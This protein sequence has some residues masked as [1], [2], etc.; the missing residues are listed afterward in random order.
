MC[1]QGLVQAFG[2]SAPAA[3][4]ADW[5]LCMKLM[6]IGADHEVTGSC[7]VLEVG[8]H[9]LL[10]DCGM[11]QGRDLYQNADLPV[12]PSRVDA[13][14]L[15]HAHMDHAGRIPWLYTQG[16][17]GPVYTTSATAELSQ[18][19]LRDS[20]HI[21]ESEAEWKNRKNRRA[22]LPEITPLYTVNDANEVLK[23]F[24]P[25]E[26]GQEIEVMPGVT[27]HFEDVGHLLGSASIHLS[28][29]EEKESRT[30][31]FSG[32][33][34]NENQPIIRDPGMLE[35][36]D[37]VLMESTYGDR[38]HTDVPDYIPPLVR[39]MQE[40]FNRGGNLVIPCFAVGRT[41]QML[42]FMRKIVQEKLVS[43]PGGFSVYVD[44]PLAV[45][46]TKIFEK[47]IFGYFDDDA[48][49][50]VRE[51]IN[52]IRFEGLKLS[53]TSEESKAINFDEQP[54]VILSA[55]GMCEAGRIRHHLKHNLWRAESTILFV[56]YQAEGTL[57]RRLLEGAREV[58]LFGEDI[59][60]NA[61]IEQLPGVSGH[62]DRDGLVRW[63]TSMTKKPE[64][65]FVVHGEDQVCDHFASYLKEEKGYCAEAPYSGA[66][67]DLLSAVWVKAGEPV[68]VVRKTEKPAA[69]RKATVYDQLWAAGQRLIAVIRRNEGGA[70]R[71]LAKF[72]GQIQNLCD[73][74]DR[75]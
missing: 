54:K 33:L 60:V 61:R 29:T 52:P 56:G 4:S 43:C 2:C 37:Y 5:R 51:G 12:P 6:F 45:E 39:L 49:K 65:V 30:L 22:G 17:R 18:I 69:R 58:T 42:Y 75:V 55:S 40:T 34:G 63:L 10:L 11:E 67:F 66:E 35:N 31:V 24:V 26:Y 20:A 73:K 36:A 48:M 7:H 47:N 15:S 64:R 9:Y 46:A 23:L 21:Q 70:N 32:D 25:V 19:M 27:A 50:L 3:V 62:A 44:S 13:V 28:L 38:L 14:L 59:E 57:G 16:F 8:G 72:A 68:P 74:W 1:E 71:D 53:V 41:Q